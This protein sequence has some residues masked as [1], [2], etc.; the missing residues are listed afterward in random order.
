[1]FFFNQNT[2]L[3]VTD[4]TEVDGIKSILTLSRVAQFIY[5]LSSK[6]CIIKYES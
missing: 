4:A 3:Q 1:M 2:E 6:L 5:I